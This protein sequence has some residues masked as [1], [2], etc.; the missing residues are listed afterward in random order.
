[1]KKFLNFMNGKLDAVRSIELVYRVLIII[2]TTVLL[3]FATLGWMTLAILAIIVGILYLAYKFDQG[4]I[5]KA[6]F[7]VFNSMWKLYIYVWIWIF[8]DHD[9]FESVQTGLDSFMESES[10]SDSH[11]E[12]EVTVDSDEVKID[13]NDCKND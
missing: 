6:V 11:L 5:A 4:E 8:N 3:V 2:F 9:E 7:Q 13:P 12:T 10:K 1:M